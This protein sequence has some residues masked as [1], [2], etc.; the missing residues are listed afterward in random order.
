MGK[1]TFLPS[2]R[3]YEY[4]EGESVFDVAQREDIE[5]DTACVGQGTCGLCR[6]FI[7][8]GLSSLLR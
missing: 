4:Q 8:E 6:I 7:L 2:G 5:V 1:I 3:V